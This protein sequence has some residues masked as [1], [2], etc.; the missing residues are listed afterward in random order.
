MSVEQ[1]AVAD[2][3]KL[4]DRRISTLTQVARKLRKKAQASCEVS[5]WIGGS[6]WQCSTQRKAIA[7]FLAQDDFVVDYDDHGEPNE[8]LDYDL[9]VLMVVSPGTVAEALDVGDAKLP[10]NVQL[11]LAD[12]FKDSYVYKAVSRRGSLRV[13][14][15][16]SL[17]DL[18]DWKPDLPLRVIEE[19]N[20]VR[21][22]LYRQQQ[23]QQPPAGVTIGEANMVNIT[24]I[25]NNVIGVGANVA[26]PQSTIHQTNVGNTHVDNS[27]RDV[28]DLISTIGTTLESLGS[29][30]QQ[31]I[32]NAM[33]DATAELEKPEPSKD[34][35]GQAVERALK[36][37]NNTAA[38]A[39]VIAKLKEPVAKLGTWLGEHWDKLTIYLK[40]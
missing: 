10:C 9:V 38:F 18:R 8:L 33:S 31:K 35:V 14:S 22:K 6:T 3:K 20:S 5:V 19:A 11:Y 15:L 39:G 13:T 23:Q 32:R 26:N 12:M 25:R 29:P 24:D 28:R 2:W 4:F 17:D 34:E 27:L 1:E 36:Y 7:E 21:L 40:Q 37:A 16:F 30:D